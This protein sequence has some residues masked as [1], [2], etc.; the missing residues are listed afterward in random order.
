M[1][2]RDAWGPTPPASVG[3]AQPGVSVAFARVGARQ[4]SKRTMPKKSRAAEPKEAPYRWELHADRTGRVV[5]NELDDCLQSGCRTQSEFE[6]FS[7][8]VQARLERA[9]AGGLGVPGIPGPDPVVTQPALW[10]IRWS[11]GSKRELRLYHAEPVLHPD[12]LLALKYHWK[13]IQGLSGSQIADAQDAEMAD[14]AQ[15]FQASPYHSADDD[16]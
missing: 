10:E 9:E 11:F 8:Q 3:G 4:H 15:R 6:M 16:A 7:A 2:A 5:E 13:Q 14:A 1:V 12:V